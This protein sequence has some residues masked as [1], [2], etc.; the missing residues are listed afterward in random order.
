MTSHDQR[1][2][3]LVRLLLVIATALAACPPPADLMVIGN[4]EKIVFDAPTGQPRHHA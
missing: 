4:D 1:A 2:L 3:A